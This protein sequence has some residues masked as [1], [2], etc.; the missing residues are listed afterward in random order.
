MGESAVLDGRNC[1]SRG[2]INVLGATA[3]TYVL[4][5]QVKGDAMNLRRIF[6]VLELIILVFRVL[7][8]KYVTKF[9]KFPFI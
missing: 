9:I 4:A 1:S 5:K 2:P 3:M 8:I 7:C 6:C